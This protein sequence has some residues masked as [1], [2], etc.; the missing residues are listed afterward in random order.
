MKVSSIVKF[1][2]LF[3]C[4]IFSTYSLADIGDGPRAYLPP[5]VNANVFSF[6]GMKVSGNSMINSGL[7]N[8]NLE[9]DVDLLV[10]QYTRTVDLFGN[11][12][13][14]TVVQPYGEL[15]SKV[16][17][18]VLDQLNSTTE[19]KGLGDT[20][21]LFSFGLY[22][23]PPLT[24]QQY[25]NY[26]PTFAAGALLRLTLPTGEFTDQ[27]AANLG[28]NRYSIQLGVPMTFGFGDSFL[29][30]NL[31]TI[32]F[33]PSVTFFDDNDDPFNAS[34]TGQKPIYKLESHLTHNFNPGIWT[35]LDA[36][37]AYGGETDSNGVDQD[38]RQQS[39]SAGVTLGVQFSKVLGIKASYGKVVDRNDDGMDG[40]FMRI[41]ITYTKF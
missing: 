40:D 15:Q 3:Q 2:L 7:V 23:L 30:P 25:K 21:L 20:Q 32:D 36:V 29:D 8:P 16:K 19:S 11:Y 9:L 12:A 14:F 22:N 26:K 35:S 37:Y 4:C 10:A 5:P 13:S 17:F 28:A 24:I 33:V 38:N 34:S 27:Q 18:D 39:L 31:T 41:N 6:Y 1:F